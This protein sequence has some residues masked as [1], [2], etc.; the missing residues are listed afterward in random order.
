VTIEDDM[1]VL[2]RYRSGASLSYHLTAYL[3]W[4]GYRV[5]FNGT[6]GRLELE[7]VERTHVDG[8]PPRATHTSERIVVQRLWERP[9]AIPFEVEDGGHSG[10]DARFLD[11]LFGD[12]RDDVLGRRSN[13]VDG[14]FAVLP[15][16]G[17]N[18]SFATGRPVELARL[19]GRE[20]DFVPGPPVVD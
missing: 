5:A 17:A 7:A 20:A 2:L 12:G 6:R 10:A 3:P 16:I 4:E 1:A 11:D 13:E 9:E 18:A 14:V 19:L 15:G 8:A